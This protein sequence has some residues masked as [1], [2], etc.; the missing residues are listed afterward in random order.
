VISDLDLSTDKLEWDGGTIGTVKAKALGNGGVRILPLSL[1][2]S[3]IKLI[4][5]NSNFVANGAA[6]FTFGTRTFL[7]M[8]NSI[9][10]FSIIA[11]NNGQNDA[12]VEITGYTGGSL[13]NLTINRV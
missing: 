5:T 7:A 8:N 4:L 6:T 10:G 3:Y 9:A 2:E 12:I 11:D 1:T 13:D